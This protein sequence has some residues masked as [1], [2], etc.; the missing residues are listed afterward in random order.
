ERLRPPVAAEPAKK[1][2]DVLK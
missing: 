2:S 1:A